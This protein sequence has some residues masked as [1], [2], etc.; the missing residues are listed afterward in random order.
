M[1]LTIQEPILSSTTLRSTPLAPV[2]ACAV[3][4]V[5]QTRLCGN[6]DGIQVQAWGAR[7]A[8][9]ESGSEPSDLLDQLIQKYGRHPAYDRD[10]ASHWNPVAVAWLERALAQRHQSEGPRSARTFS[11]VSHGICSLRLLAKRIQPDTFSG[12]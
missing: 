1:S 5:P 9:T 6:V 4:D 8:R 10:H 12:T 11:A 3:F 7:S 2:I